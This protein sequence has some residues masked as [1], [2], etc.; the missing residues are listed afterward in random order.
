[1]K[2]QYLGDSVYCAIERG[3]IKIT[4]ENGYDP[5]NVIYLEL[6]VYEALQKYVQR[7]IEHF[8]KATDQISDVE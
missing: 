6:G 4:T 1:M 7:A 8:S 5:S 3:M 2:K